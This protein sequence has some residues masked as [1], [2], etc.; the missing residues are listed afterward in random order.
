M[1]AKKSGGGSA[2]TGRPRAYWATAPYAGEIRE[3]ALAPS[4][5]DGLIV[6]ALYSGISR[7][8]EALVAAGRVPRSQH[9]AMRCPFQEGDFPFPVKYGYSSVGEVVD[10]PDSWLGVKVFCLYPHQTLYRVS[11]DDVQLLPE[12]LPP[13]RAVLGALMETALNGVWDSEAKAGDRVIVLGAGVLG[14]LTA[15]LLNALPGSEVMLVD[16]EPERRG[17]TEKL[18]LAF[19]LP[20]EI[21]QPADVILDCTGSPDALGRALAWTVLE[22]RI[23]EMSW[24]GDRPVTL[25]LGED[26]HS[27]RLTIRSSQVGSVA[28]SQ[29][30]RWTRKRRLAKALEL[31]QAEILDALIE[32]EVAFDDLPEVLPRLAR[33]VEPALCLRVRYD[34]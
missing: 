4:E 11:A 28:A 27:K 30:P 21:V 5:E 29:R 34:D 18:G 32:A 9:G 10:G 2:A 6:K 19:A 24:F 7:G 14:L 1:A 16:I 31:L 33:Q 12:E 17:I 15:W 20:E 3:T 22:S 25:P 23:V 8:T 26:F 13:Q